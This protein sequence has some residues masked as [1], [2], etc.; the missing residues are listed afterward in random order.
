MV[1]LTY[2]TV[3]LMSRDYTV[4]KQRCHYA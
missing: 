4:S 3:G 1:L 2:A